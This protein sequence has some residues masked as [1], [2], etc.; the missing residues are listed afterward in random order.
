MEDLCFALYILAKDIYIKLSYCSGY[1]WWIW[2]NNWR[3]WFVG[4]VMIFWCYDIY[5]DKSLLTLIEV[6]MRIRKIYVSFIVIFTR[7]IFSV[8]FVYPKN[9]TFN[10]FSVLDF[11]FLGLA[12]NIHIEC[13]EYVICFSIVIEVLRT[14]EIWYFTSQ[15]MIYNYEYKNSQISRKY[16][17]TKNHYPLTTN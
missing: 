4:Y 6:G 17:R 15:R 9:N 14:N 12:F 13:F 7:R 16:F 3:P 10:W 1:S 11:L 5:V 8:S 2:F